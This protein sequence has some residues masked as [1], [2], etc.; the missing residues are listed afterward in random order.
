MRGRGIVDCR[1]ITEREAIGGSFL[2]SYDGT[3]LG[4]LYERSKLFLSFSPKYDVEPALTVSR[5]LS[6]DG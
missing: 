4:A 6:Q 3:G 5:E 2:Y 1:C